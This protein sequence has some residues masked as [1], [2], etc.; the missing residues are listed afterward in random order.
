MNFNIGSGV[1]YIS[2]KGFTHYP[3]AANS[4]G[5]KPVFV[6]GAMTKESVLDI[7]ENASSSPL[8]MAFPALVI[9]SDIGLSFEEV[10]N[11][12]CKVTQKIEELNTAFSGD[13]NWHIDG[14]LEPNGIINLNEYLEPQS[15]VLNVPQVV[16][17]VFGFPD[18][19]KRN[20]YFQDVDAPSLT[21]SEVSVRNGDFVIRTFGQ[22]LK[23]KAY[24]VNV[25][26]R[27]TRTQPERHPVRIGIYW[28]GE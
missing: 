23:R 25:P 4:E 24:K 27:T 13:L 16:Q 1:I 19:F 21:T 11:T 22:D 5:R 10:E 15:P 28:I 12:I 2:S 14:C 7:V 6:A 20:S 8:F 9:S 26:H 17:W 18:I 3:F